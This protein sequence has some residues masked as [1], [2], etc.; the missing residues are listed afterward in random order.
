MWVRA[1][2][3]ASESF[4]LESGHMDS[5]QAV[6]VDLLRYDDSNAAAGMEDEVGFQLVIR[7]TLRAPLITR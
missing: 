5:R 7:P 2:T 3:R 4:I 1:Q 6:D